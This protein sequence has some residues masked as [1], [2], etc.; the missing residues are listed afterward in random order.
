MLEMI[1]STIKL[2]GVDHQLAV[3]IDVIE[4]EYVNSDGE[5]MVK[6]YN[7]PFRLL[8]FSANSESTRQCIREELD[9]II[10]SYLFDP[11]YIH[12]KPML[13]DCIVLRNNIIRHV[14]GDNQ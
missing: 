7:T 4:E 1:I 2:K 5:R 12:D 10:N 8:G 13:N 14:Y 11:S 6:I 3:P 9:L